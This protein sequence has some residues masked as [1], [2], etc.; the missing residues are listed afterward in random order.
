MAPITADIN[1]GNT[2]L[3]GWFKFFFLKKIYIVH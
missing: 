3:N 1:K 2:Y